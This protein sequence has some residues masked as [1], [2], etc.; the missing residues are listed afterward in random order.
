MMMQLEH[1]RLM[2]ERDETI[3]HLELVSQQKSAY[4]Q[5]EIERLRAELEGLRVRDAGPSRREPSGVDE[6]DDDD[7]DE[8]GAES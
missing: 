6:N 5:S 8:D 1:A 3:H 4:Y 7:Y 2:P